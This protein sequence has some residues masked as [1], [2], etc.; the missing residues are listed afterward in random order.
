VDVPDDVPD[1]VP[2][3]LPVAPSMES[4]VPLPSRSIRL[5]GRVTAPGA[6][7]PDGLYA[8]PLDPG[9]WVGLPGRAVEPAPIPVEPAPGDA[10]APLLPADPPAP[11]PDPLP[12]PLPANAAVDIT[13]N[14]P[15]SIVLS[16]ISV[17]VLCC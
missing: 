8:L 9:D 1:V 6:A 4:A 11:P 3:E 15:V 5:S 13:I 10:P 7:L 2:D 12:P 17:H 16:F 14:A